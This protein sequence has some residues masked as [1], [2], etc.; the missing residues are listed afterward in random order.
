MFFALYN[1]VKIIFLR[2]FCENLLML[3]IGIFGVCVEVFFL[4]MCNFNKKINLLYSKRKK[5]SA[6]SQICAFL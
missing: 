4:N 3:R 2:A 1:N 6:S 5:K